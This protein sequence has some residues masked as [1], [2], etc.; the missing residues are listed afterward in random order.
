MISP[1]K[2]VSSRLAINA[3]PKPIERREPKMPTRI[4]SAQP[5]IRPK[6]KRNI[7]IVF[8][9]LKVTKSVEVNI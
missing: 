2:G 6:L 4:D 8:C 7:G 3:Q 1:M 5:D 9:Y